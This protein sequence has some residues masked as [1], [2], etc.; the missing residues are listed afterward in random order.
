MKPFNEDYTNLGCEIFH[1]DTNARGNWELYYGDDS[2]HIEASWHKNS[3]LDRNGWVC[4]T[5][6][7][8]DALWG[9]YATFDFTI[10]FDEFWDATGWW[11]DVI[12]KLKDDGYRHHI[13]TKFF[14]DIQQNGWW[15]ALLRFHY[16]VTRTDCQDMDIRSHEV[17]IA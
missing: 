17:L 13:P 16:E 4:V 14:D 11:W 9:H 8:H 2:L 6:I 12:E 10:E 7:L 3:P 1:T 5:V 15:S